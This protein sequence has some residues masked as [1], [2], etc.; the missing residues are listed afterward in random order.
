MCAKFPNGPLK[1]S[2]LLSQDEIKGAVHPRAKVQSLLLR[3]FP[4]PQRF[5]QRLESGARTEGQREFG[6]DE[7]G[8]GMDATSWP[9]LRT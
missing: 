8:F 1:S 5:T 6:Q 3:M 9:K 2:Y 7:G 4:G